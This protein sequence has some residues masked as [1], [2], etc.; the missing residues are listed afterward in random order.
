MKVLVAYMSKTGN[1]KKVAEAILDEIKCE[2][3]IMNVKEVKDIEDY[4]LA[5]L[6]FPMHNLGPDAKTK[7]FLQRYRNS[8]KKMALFITHA[9]PEDHE[10]L[11]EMLEKFEQAV[12]GAN[13]VGMFDCQGELAKAVRFLMSVHPDSRFRQWAKEDD[14]KGQPDETR[15][16][17]ARVFAQA[18]MGEYGY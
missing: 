13:M 8:D 7:K 5:F 1:T 11:P 18:I 2:K 17:K 12:S 9:T 14:S 10:A 6:G 4:D 16:E 3:E 15:L